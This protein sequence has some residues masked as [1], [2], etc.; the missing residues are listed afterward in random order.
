MAKCRF[1]DG[2]GKYVCTVCKGTKYVARINYTAKKMFP[3]YYDL[4]SITCP[5]CEGTGYM[6][7]VVCHGT[8]EDDE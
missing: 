4:E 2:Q 8:G 7:C 6:T 5:Y 1:C 3:Q